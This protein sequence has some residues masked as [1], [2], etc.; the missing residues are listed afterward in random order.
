MENAACAWLFRTNQIHSIACMCFEGR[1]G[2]SVDAEEI[3]A[4]ECH[5]L[6]EMRIRLVG[7]ATSLHALVFMGYVE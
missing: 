7:R 4:H 3:R 1:E 2:G 5:V 6:F